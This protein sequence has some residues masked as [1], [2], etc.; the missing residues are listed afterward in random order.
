MS[1]QTPYEQQIDPSIIGTGPN[2]HEERDK[3]VDADQ[4]VLFTDPEL[5]RV[6]EEERGRMPTLLDDEPDS[7]AIKPGGKAQQPVR[8]VSFEC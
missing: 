4:L 1:T 6:R 2:G 3:S 7:K 5:V 8:I